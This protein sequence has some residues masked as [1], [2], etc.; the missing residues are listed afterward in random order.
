MGFSDIDRKATEKYEP[1]KFLKKLAE[2]HGVDWKSAKSESDLRRLIDEKKSKEVTKLEP[3]K[4][5]EI[6]KNGAGPYP[7]GPNIVI[8]VPVPTIN[9]AH[10]VGPQWWNIVENVKDA[11]LYMV[12]GAALYAVASRFLGF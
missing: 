8:N 3:V 9:M 7:W 2:K 12:V 10:L 1:S 11:A 6:V 4:D 5:G